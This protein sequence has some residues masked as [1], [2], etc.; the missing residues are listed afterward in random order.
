MTAPVLTPAISD[1]RS[2]AV[3]AVYLTATAALRARLLGFVTTAFAGQGD[4]RDAAAAAFVA[5]V[6]PMVLAAQQ[7]MVPLTDAYLAHF[8]AT[9]TNTVAS[10]V[11]IAA[12][13]VTGT[14][15]R[16]V[17]PTEVYRRPYT[18]V[19]TDLSRGKT[20][21][22]A[23]AAG[24]RRAV[25]IAATDLQLARTRTAQQV[26]QQ[27]TKHV[28][29]YR[30]E[31]GP[32]THHCAMCLLTSSRIYH[33]ADLMPLHPGCSCT[34]TPIFRGEEVPEVDP[35]LLHDTVRRDLGDKYVRASG[36]GP[37]DYRDIIITRD[38]GELG[39]VLAVRGQDFTGPSDIPGG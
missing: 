1:P 37:V 24:Q 28:I 25:T 26:L 12:T 6:V 3:A 32:G 30:R 17:N 15:T 20:L 2:A 35:A 16:G 8:I 7:T 22:Q 38:H 39:P 14:A 10:P 19:W 5:N 27:S 21:D 9:A 11:G 33:K 29:G 31:L 18:Q 4:Y 36:H 23:V 34:P 13:S